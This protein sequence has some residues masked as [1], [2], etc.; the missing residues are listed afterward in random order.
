MNID[1]RSVVVS[2]GSDKHD[3][4]VPSTVEVFG[5]NDLGGGYSFE[6]TITRVE[7]RDTSA[8]RKIKV[9]VIDRPETVKRNQRRSAFRLDMSLPATIAWEKDDTAFVFTATVVDMSFTGCRL[10]IDPDAPGQDGTESDRLEAFLSATSHALSFAPPDDFACSERAREQKRQQE[11]GRNG[12]KEI[13]EPDWGTYRDIS[14][15]IVLTGTKKRGRRGPIYVVGVKFEESP[16]INRLIRFLERQL[17]Q[18]AR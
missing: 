6:S 5:R 8:G 7:W 14:V 3:P 9:W 10:H 13:A 11:K 16:A 2:A 1:N 4:L 15:E 12:E 18:F 17:L